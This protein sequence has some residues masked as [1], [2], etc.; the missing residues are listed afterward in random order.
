MQAVPT[1]NIMRPLRSIVLLLS[2]LLSPSLSAQQSSSPSVPVRPVVV[3]AP[4]AS[5]IQIDGRLDE[6]AWAA[7]PAS[8]DFTQVDP[9]EGQPVSEAT[10]ARVLFDDE[11]IYIG[12]RLRDRQPVSERL[13]RR[14]MDLLDS[15]WLGVVIDSYHDHRTA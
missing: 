7:A 11:A 14:D 8:T 13:G 5:A 6:A 10:E 2:I 4:A 12:V 3:A 1:G 15:D 9:E